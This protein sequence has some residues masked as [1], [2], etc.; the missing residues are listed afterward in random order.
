VLCCSL[1]VVSGCAIQTGVKQYPRQWPSLVAEPNVSNCDWINGDYKDSG[2]V[3]ESSAQQ[4]GQR[5]K[6]STSLYGYLFKNAG[7]FFSGSAAE[8]ENIATSIRL[9]WDASVGLT[10][11]ALRNGDDRISTTI[12][13][14][15]A[16]CEQGAIVLHGSW[17]PTSGEGAQFGFDKSTLSFMAA[18]GRVLI[19]HEIYLSR[20]VDFLVFPV[21]ERSDSW[22]LF[23]L[24]TG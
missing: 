24:D 3:G 23:E 7:V 8:V 16:S 22:S 1:A 18:E 11:V 4:H 14:S 13:A 21:P 5:P 20:T 17:V 12:P 6:L 15:K 19:V 2:V 9:R 10:A